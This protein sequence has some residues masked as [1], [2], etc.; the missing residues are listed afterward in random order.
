MVEAVKIDYKNIKRVFGSMRSSF[1]IPKKS[2]I[3]LVEVRNGRFPISPR[4]NTNPLF[5][6][7]L[8]EYLLTQENRIFIAHTSLLKIGRGDYSFGNLTK[9]N[10]T[11][12]LRKLPNVKFVNLDNVRSI[13]VE[14]G[15][16]KFNIPEILRAADYYIDLAKMKTHMETQVSLCLKNQMGLL[17]AENKKNMHRQGLE[18]GIA[19]LS[20]DK[21]GFIHN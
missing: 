13:L 10:A 1:N 3:L 21:T 20:S 18:Q 7:S 5:L 14:I 4:E 17:S 15:N 9:L 12:R 2:S 8:V 19:L 6:E 11:K 16:Y